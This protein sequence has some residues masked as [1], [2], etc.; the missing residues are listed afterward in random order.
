MR[1]WRSAETG[2]GRDGAWPANIDRCAAAGKEG[3]TN[4]ASTEVA[5]SVPDLVKDPI[6]MVAAGQ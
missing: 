4:S 3:G 5:R 1:P 6:A 2:A